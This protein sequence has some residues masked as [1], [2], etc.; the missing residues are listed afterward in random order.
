MC[1]VKLQILQKMQDFMR[2]EKSNLGKFIE[3][4]TNDKKK[5][6]LYTKPIKSSQK[7]KSMT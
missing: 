4:H 3:T 5:K 1:K 7:L 6:N 2:S